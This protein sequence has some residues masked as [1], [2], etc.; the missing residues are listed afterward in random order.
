MP[1]LS[2]VTTSTLVA[3]NTILL[4]IVG[5]LFMRLINALDA[6]TKK[7]QEIELKN[8][9][10]QSQITNI[11]EKIL[12]LVRLVGVP[13]KIASIEKSISSIKSDIN[14]LRERQHDI[15]NKMNGI[16]GM[17]QLEELKKQHFALK[18][19]ITKD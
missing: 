2:S 12:E 3:I 18:P 5:I 15:A 1:E 16:Y 11:T 6:V 10:I 17:C 19:W 9:A 14:Q 4:G 7:Q 13:D 8:V